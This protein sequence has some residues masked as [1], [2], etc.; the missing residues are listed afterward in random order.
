[1]TSAKHTVQRQ[2]AKRGRP[3]TFDTDQALDTIL[4]VFWARGY[5]ATSYRMLVEATGINQPSLYAA[6]GDKAALFDKALDRYFVFYGDRDLAVLGEDGGDT[7][8]AISNWLAKSAR[9]LTDRSHPPGCLVIH[10]LSECGEGGPGGSNARECLAL[11]ER[12][13]LKTLKKGVSHGT[14]RP[15]TDV[16]SLARTLAV[17]RSGMAVAAR[18]G[19]SREQLTGVAETLSELIPT[20]TGQAGQKQGPADH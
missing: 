10:T 13:L 14:I 16:S 12:A 20:V 4:Q 9:D 7:K 11:I 18:A 15:D 8:A 1:M 3:R 17:G 6:F 19:A 5:A 2:E